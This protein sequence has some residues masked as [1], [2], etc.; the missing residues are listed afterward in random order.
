MKELFTPNLGKD[1][2]ASS[3]KPPKAESEP[4]DNEEEPSTIR[5]ALY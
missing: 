2:E 4:E 5:Q 3:E 1:P